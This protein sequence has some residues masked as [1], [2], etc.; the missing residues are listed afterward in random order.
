MKFIDGNI[1]DMGSA[2]VAVLCVFIKPFVRWRR[3]ISPCWVRRDVTVDLLNGA[4]VLPFILLIVSVFSTKVLAVV[5]HGSGM[6]FVFAGGIGLLFVAGE[7]MPSKADTISGE[8]TSTGLVKGKVPEKPKAV[9]EDEAIKNK[10][11]EEEKKKAAS[12]GRA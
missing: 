7:L 5:Q 1:L 12:Q 8:E 10:E 6:A 3:N 9:V 2:V 11:Q 4:I